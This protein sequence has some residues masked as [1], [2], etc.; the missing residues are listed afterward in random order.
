ML[1][2]TFTEHGKEL[3]PRPHIT[4]SLAIR[5]SIQLTKRERYS[6]GA[7]PVSFLK[8]LRKALLSS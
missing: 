5:N 2:Q 3:S 6:P 4:F 1:S 8:S 7:S